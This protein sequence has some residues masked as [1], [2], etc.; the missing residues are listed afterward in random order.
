[1][2][3]TVSRWRAPVM[4]AAAGVLV[5]AALAGSSALGS[6]G[7]S[8]AAIKAAHASDAPSARLAGKAHASSAAPGVGPFLDAVAQLAQAGTI[9]DAQAHVLDAD[10][11]AGSIDPQQLV[12]SGTLSSV[13]MQAVG[14]RLDAVKRS[15]ASAN[16]D[17]CASGG[18]RPKAPQG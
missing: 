18:G 16:Q 17:N 7:R 15:L 13:Q 2:S 1:M 3:S 11:R 8:A 9:T 4:G 6:G 14:D 12:A 5:A 10:I